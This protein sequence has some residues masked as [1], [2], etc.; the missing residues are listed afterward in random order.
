MMSVILAK[1]DY[2]QSANNVYYNL[3][4]NERLFELEANV[5]NYVK[6]SLLR[7]EEIDDFYVNGIYVET[8]ETNNGYELCFD[9]YVMNIEIY[10]KQIIYFD[11]RK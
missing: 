6:C 11:I 1:S 5:I 2:L 4:E 8:Y 3:Q 10:D 7:N 9:D